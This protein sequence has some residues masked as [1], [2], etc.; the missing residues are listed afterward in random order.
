MASKMTRN[1]FLLK[2]RE[3]ERRIRRRVI[4]LGVIY[5]IQLVAAPASIVL[6]VLLWKYWD[7]EARNIVLTESVF[8]ILLFAGSLFAER[9]SRR[10][11][12]R[13]ALRCPFCGICLVFIPGKKTVDT[14]LCYSCG[15]RII[16]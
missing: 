15:K 10:H 9:D 4:P 3:S 14:G 1:E 6:M 13:L 2:K 12:D 7:T 16:E 11:Y 8:C 5:S